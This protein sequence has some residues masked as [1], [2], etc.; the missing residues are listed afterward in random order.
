[1][2]L[3][4]YSLP[5]RMKE[6]GM[7]ARGNHIRSAFSSHAASG[8]A[9]MSVHNGKLGSAG[10]LQGELA[11]CSIVLPFCPYLRGRADELERAVPRGCV[12]PDC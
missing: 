11:S 10:G 4:Y 5:C 1:M 8:I 2:W 6:K 12:L 3:I 7:A 9:K